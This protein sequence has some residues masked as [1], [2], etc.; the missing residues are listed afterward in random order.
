MFS[1]PTCLRLRSSSMNIGNGLAVVYLSIVG[2]HKIL[3]PA[4][5]LF[6]SLV[7]VSTHIIYGRYVSMVWLKNMISIGWG[8][9]FPH[10]SPLLSSHHFQHLSTSLSHLFM[11]LFWP[12]FVS[13]HILHN[14]YSTIVTASNSSIIT[15]LDILFILLSRPLKAINDHWGNPWGFLFGISTSFL[16]CNSEGRPGC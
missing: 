10:H 14:V 9:S 3:S 6:P 15:F 12:S 1:A 5:G 4:C 8:A 2:W 13:P 16:Y 11:V 7:L